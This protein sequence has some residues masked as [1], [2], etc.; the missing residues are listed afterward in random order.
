M[1]VLDYNLQN[2][3]LTE[4]ETQIFNAVKE[5]GEM[6]DCHA[7]HP[8]DVSEY[9]KIPMNQM[10]G[11]MSSLSKKG[12]CYI[13]ELISGCGDWIILFEDK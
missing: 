8:E 4:M 6:D 9:T 13:D 2:V 1:T 11:V 12:V 7:S 10:R 3:E 5:I